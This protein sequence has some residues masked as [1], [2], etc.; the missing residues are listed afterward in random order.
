MAKSFKDRLNSIRQ[1]HSY[2]VEKVKI[3]FVRGITRVMRQKGITNSALAEQV[4]T[5]NAYIT[6]VLRGDCNFTIDSM[7]KIAHGIGATIHVHVADNA[8]SVRWL[9][10]HTSK[11]D[12]ASDAVPLERAGRDATPDNVIDLKCIRETIRNVG[13]KLYA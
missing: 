1:L 2:R 6:K 7:V 12:Q 11:D 13:S 5:S 4:G 8:A 10:K 3:E 9:E